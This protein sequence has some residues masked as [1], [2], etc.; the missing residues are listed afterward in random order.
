MRELRIAIPDHDRA[1]QALRDTDALTR[2]LAGHGALPVWVSYGDGHRTI[3]LLAAGDVH[4]AATGPVPPLRARSEGVDVVYVA[5]CAPVAVR[6]RVLVRA[7]S[8]IADL[9]ALRGR[10]VALERGSAPTLAL[11]ELL[12]RSGGAIAYRDLDIELLPSEIARRA[13]IDGHVDAWFDHTGQ[14]GAAIDELPGGVIETADQTVWFARRD[15][16]APL[17]E[18]LM[19]VIALDPCGAEPVTRT[20]LAEQQRRADLL[21]GQ[22]AIGLPVDLG[23]CV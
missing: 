23:A 15:A 14:S 13:L 4:V 21:A 18:A 12:E 11:A 9:A 17:V 19:S 22:G 10:R 16:P 2:R 3:D 20:F 8:A 7:G 1:L 5:A 6:A